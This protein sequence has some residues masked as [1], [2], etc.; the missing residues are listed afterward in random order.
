MRDL[1]AQDVLTQEHANQ[2]IGVIDQ[3]LTDISMAQAKLGASQNALEHRM[4]AQELTEI[5]LAESKS[6]IQDTDF[7]E[8][9]MASA[10]SSAKTD[11]GVM[12]RVQ[13]NAKK[14]DVMHL[15]K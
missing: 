9:L 12:L 5:H 15:L 13:A 4:H 14:S 7:A 6:R 1:P 11:I 8:S 2:S 3:A 10:I